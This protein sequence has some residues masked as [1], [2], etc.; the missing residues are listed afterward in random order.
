MVVMP[1]FDPELCDGCGLCVAAC[2]GDGIVLRGGRVWITETENC[3]FCGVCEAVCLQQA[4]TCHYVI[5][6]SED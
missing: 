1:E 3:D 6:L 5:V 4:I 2:H